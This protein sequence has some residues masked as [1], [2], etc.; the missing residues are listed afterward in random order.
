VETL[1]LGTCLNGEPHSWGCKDTKGLASLID[2]TTLVEKCQM[3]WD[4]DSWTESSG[5]LAALPWLLAAFMLTHDDPSADD[6]AWR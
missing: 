1:W 6:C 4:W 3:N 5:G 2:N